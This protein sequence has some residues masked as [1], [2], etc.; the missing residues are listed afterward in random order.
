[1]SPSP[2]PVEFNELIAI[3][4]QV[5]LTPTK[6]RA[7]SATLNMMADA[8]EEDESAKDS[9][10]AATPANSPVLFQ[11]QHPSSDYGS[12][13]SGGTIASF[14]PTS[15][16]EAHLNNPSDTDSGYW[17]LASLPPTSPPAHVSSPPSP[18]RS[19]PSFA[20]SRQEKHAR[21]AA[22]FVAMK[23]K[24][25]HNESQQYSGN[26][27]VVL[28]T[29]VPQA[30]NDHTHFGNAAGS[31]AQ[32]PAFGVTSPS[33]TSSCT[34]RPA[35]PEGAYF[36]VYRLPNR[37]PLTFYVAP[38]LPKASLYVVTRGREIGIFSGWTRVLPLIHRVQGASYVKISS[39][40]QGEEIMWEEY[41][42]GTCMV[43]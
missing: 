23:A 14:S 18:P 21:W 16:I 5:K 7:L 6:A 31:T 34:K 33:L 11:S 19:P 42:R 12:T 9:P 8:I 25:Q 15:V 13:S 10:P 4:A 43:I 40:E 17:S 1:M 35:T 38:P 32:L 29:A 39:I 37:S 3:L 26:Q 2:S 27:S 22:A 41:T 20:L 36:R 30:S 28:R 24:Q